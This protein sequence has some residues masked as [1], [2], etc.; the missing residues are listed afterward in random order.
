MHKSRKAARNGALEIFLAAVKRVRPRRL[1]HEWISLEGDIL[2][3]GS[4]RYELAG[5]RKLYVVGFGKASAAMAAVVEEILGERISGGHVITKY[6]HAVPL[7]RIAITE[8]GHPLPDEKGLQGTRA[9]LQI[10]EKTNFNDLVLCLISGGGSALLADVPPG[11]SL[12]DIKKLNE[13]LIRSG[14]GI[15]EIN[16]IRKHL[17]SVKGGQLA[18]AAHPAQLISL[19][20][21][22][23]VGDP[24]D[25]IASG[26]TVPDP[27]TFDDALAVIDKYHLRQEI[28]AS[29]LT[30]LQ[31][32]ATGSLAETPKGDDKVFENSHNLLIGNNRMALEAAARKAEELGYQPGIITSGLQ[33][34]VQDVARQIV[35]AAIG[36]R[37]K[38]QGQKFCLLFGGEPT[39]KVQ[40]SGLG[41]RNQHLALLAAS[42]LKDEVGITI[43]SGGTDGSDGPTDAAGAV[44]DAHTLSNAR[45]LGLDPLEYLRNFDAYHFFRQEGGLLITGPTQTNVMDV[46][47]VLVEGVRSQASGLGLH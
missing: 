14:A 31:Q 10:L 5:S 33:G 36:E 38:L 20:L 46:V 43:L 17:S 44:V 2:K 32:G 27:T 16:T 30:Q 9:I 11:A 3:L 29:L 6:G 42:M 25:M 13:L 15:H 18:R 45:L 41:G 22:D 47:V 35:D 1:M 21:S 8:A 7:S 34:D 40:G 28:A 23:V 26:P 4:Y 24:L 12:Q 19:I 39:V 37:N